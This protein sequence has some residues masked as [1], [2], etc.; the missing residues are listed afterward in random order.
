MKFLVTGGTNGMGKGVAMAL[1]P[2]HEVIVLARSEEL[3][4]ARVTELGPKA[5]YVICDLTRLSDVSAAVAKL[6]SDHQHLDGIFINAGIG[7]ARRRIETEDGMDAHFQ[8]NYLSQM[9]LLLQLLDLLEASEIG[10]RVVF[11]VAD[12]GE[13]FWDDLQMERKWGYERGIGQGMVAKRM[14]LRRLH[15]L[16]A[17]RERPLV[18]FVGFQ[19]A[20]TV[21][22]NQLNI[23]PWTLRLPARV[24]KLFGSFISIEECGHIMAPLFTEPH[25]A[26]LSRSGKMITQKS[27]AF[28]EVPEK[29]FVLDPAARERLWRLS[30]DLCDD[31]TRSIAAALEG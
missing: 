5:S 21:W 10:A 3:A 20:K 1:S 16:Y 15:E 18:S 17:G 6:R 2:D 7:Y 9:M 23:I 12:F 24:A 22:S 8:V 19:I 13:L 28:V 4:K 27:G 11:N 14:L 31:A 30:L 29:D 26:S 25:T